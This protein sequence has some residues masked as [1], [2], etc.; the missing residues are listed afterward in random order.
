MIYRSHGNGKAGVGVPIIIDIVTTAQTIP[1]RP[2]KDIAQPAPAVGYSIFQGG[3]GQ[4]PRAEQ[5]L[6]VIDRAPTIAVNIIELR[7]IG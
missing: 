4:R 5:G 6:A 2:D 3:L 1:G 7:L